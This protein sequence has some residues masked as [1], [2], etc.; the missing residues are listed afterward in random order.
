MH[1]LSVVISRSPNIRKCFVLS[2]R[3]GLLCHSR[4]SCCRG[5]Y[6]VDNHL[7]NFI[8]NILLNLKM[9]IVIKINKAT[10]AGLDTDLCIFSY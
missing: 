8:L 5:C 1:N 10:A 6:F 7:F 3:S 2:Q 4:Q 9:Q